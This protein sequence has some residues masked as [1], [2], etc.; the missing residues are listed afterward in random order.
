MY[1]FYHKRYHCFHG[2]P[3]IETNGEHNKPLSVEQEKTL[4]LYIDRCEVLGRPY[5]HKYIELAA[6][7]ILRTSDSLRLVSKSWTT[8]F[9]K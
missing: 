4:L 8:R 6:N 2:R 7:S 3:A 1:V 5:E 9:V